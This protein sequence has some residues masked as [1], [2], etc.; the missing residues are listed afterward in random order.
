MNACGT[1][2]RGAKYTE[3]ASIEEVVA[4][5]QGAFTSKSYWRLKIVERF[6]RGYST[7]EIDE[8]AKLSWL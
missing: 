1:T 5:Q 7:E 6:Y 4:G 8:T 2:E 3:N